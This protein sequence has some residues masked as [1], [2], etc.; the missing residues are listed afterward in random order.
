MCLASLMIGTL[1][2]STINIFVTKIQFKIV[3]GVLVRSRRS[4]RAHGN[5]WLCNPWSQF[6]IREKFI[7]AVWIESWYLPF[8][9]LQKM[10]CE[11][12]HFESMVL[13]ILSYIFTSFARYSDMIFLWFSLQYV[14][15]A[16]RNFLH[17]VQ[18]LYFS[19]HFRAFFRNLRV[20]H[21]KRTLINPAL[22]HLMN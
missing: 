19:R 12:E 10:F 7:V 3:K 18:L 11:I 1:K 4:D 9:H 2:D 16:F 15:T 13:C 17:F 14:N 6:I 8:Q 22:P 21:E 5:S 20:C